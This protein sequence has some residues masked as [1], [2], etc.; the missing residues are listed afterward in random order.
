MLFSFA[1]YFVCGSRFQGGLVGLVL[2]QGVLQERVD[3]LFEGQFVW[4]LNCFGEDRPGVKALYGAD[5]FHVGHSFSRS[6]A[7]T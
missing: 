1:F 4:D 5:S 7:Q 6:T 3:R 2:F